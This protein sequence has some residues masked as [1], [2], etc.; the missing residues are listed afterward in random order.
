M[1]F[2]PDRV[3]LTADRRLSSQRLARAW[4]AA[5]P[6][7]WRAAL[8]IM[9]AAVVAILAIY[10]DTAKSIVA[11]WR[12]SDT[13]A[14]GYLIVPISAFL[15]WT[16]RREVAALAPRPDVLGLALVAMV[17]ATVVAL[18][19]RRLAWALAFPL[20][21]LLLAVPFGEAFLPRLMEWSADFTVAD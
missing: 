6:S 17:L 11:I 2:E 21:V 16:K 7:A 8:P 4:R 19:G 10:A 13:F 14:H 3:L 9:A 15:I 1:K 18:A 20:G 5:P 12:S